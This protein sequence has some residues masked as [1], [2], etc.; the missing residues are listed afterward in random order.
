MSAMRTTVIVAGS[1]DRR[2]TSLPPLLL[3]AATA[4]LTDVVVMHRNILRANTS[5]ISVMVFIFANR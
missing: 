3:G 5:P 2:A 1:R 4:E